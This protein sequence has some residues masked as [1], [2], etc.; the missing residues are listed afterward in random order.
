MAGAAPGVQ[1]HA[2][3]LFSHTAQVQ[4]ARG[5]GGAGGGSRGRGGSERGAGERR[6]CTE[7]A[8]R[9]GRGQGRV[10]VRRG[11]GGTNIL[12]AILANEPNERQS[13]EYTE[14]KLVLPFTP[15]VHSQ[16]HTQQNP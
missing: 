1:H 3:K 13:Q 10:G 14:Q 9:W 8:G 12:R 15:H 16:T 2:A 5:G 11:G 7:G 6:G 4:D